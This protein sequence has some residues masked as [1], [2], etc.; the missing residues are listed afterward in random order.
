MRLKLFQFCSWCGY[1]WQ[2]TNHESNVIADNGFSL[3]DVSKTNWKLSRSQSTQLQEM[4]WANHDAKETTLLASAGKVALHSSRDW[5]EGCI[6]TLIGYEGSIF[7]LIG[8]R[9]LRQIFVSFH[10][11]ELVKCYTKPSLWLFWILI[12]RRS[13]EKRR[14]G[15]SRLT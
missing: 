1:C 14:I 7:I 4:L 11:S 9:T 12:M 8:G 5:L 10:T 15:A 3:T 13:I 2:S 6:F